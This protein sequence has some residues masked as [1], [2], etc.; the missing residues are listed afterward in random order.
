MRW[1]MTVRELGDDGGC[2]GGEV[3]PSPEMVCIPHVAVLALAPAL[4]DDWRDG[5][6]KDDRL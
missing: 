6:R 2:S 1:T 4:M 5:A 3:I